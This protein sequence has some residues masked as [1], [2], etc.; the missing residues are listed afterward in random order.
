MSQNQYR[1]PN[2][3]NVLDKDD[4]DAEQKPAVE[5]G[6]S[7]FGRRTL[8]VPKMQLIDIDVIRCK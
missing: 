6:P 8:P 5:E 1:N 2:L 4:A 7:Y 3:A